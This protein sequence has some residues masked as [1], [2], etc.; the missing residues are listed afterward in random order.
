MDPPVRLIAFVG[1]PVGVKKFRQKY[2]NGEVYMD[3]HKKSL[4]PIMG[5]GKQSVFKMAFSLVSGGE[6]KKNLKRNQAFN[7]KVEGLDY[8]G[9]KLTDDGTALASGIKRGGLWVVGPGEQGILL[10]IKE[11]VVGMVYP[12]DEIMKAVNSIY[13]NPMADDSCSTNSCSD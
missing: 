6:V 8:D 4:W 5:A 7:Q 1:S 10:E 11:S 12:K 13:V 3:E 2:W 9:S